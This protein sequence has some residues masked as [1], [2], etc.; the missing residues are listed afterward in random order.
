MTKLRPYQSEIVE[1]VLNAVEQC[2]DRI[3]AFSPPG[4]GKS[5]VILKVVEAFIARSTPT[6]VLCRRK[7]VIEQLA[8]RVRGLDL[9]DVRT[10]QS[11]ARR[12]KKMGH[13]GVIIIDEAHEGG[14][15]SQANAVINANPGAIVIYVT[16]TPTPDL[17]DACAVQVWGPPAQQLTDQCY[18]APLRYCGAKRPNLSSVRIRKGD[19]DPS[20]LLSV[21]DDKRIQGSILEAYNRWGRGG[22]CLGFCVSVKHAEDTADMLQKAGVPCEVLTGKDGKDETDRKLAFLEEGGLLLSISRVSAGFDLPNLKSILILRP[23]LSIQFHDQSLGRVAR[24][25]DDGGPGRV[26][27]LVGNVRRLGLFTSARDYGQRGD[28]EASGD[29]RDPSGDL[30]SI[31][32]CE[33]CRDIWEGSGTICTTCGHDNGRDRR[34]SKNEKARLDE[35][36]AAE[37]EAGLQAAKE[38]RKRQGQSIKQMAAWLR[39]KPGIPN[40]RAAW[41]QAISNMRKRLARAEREGDEVVA[42]FARSELRNAGV[43]PNQKPKPQPKFGLDGWP[44]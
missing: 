23:T 17:L 44:L 24:L 28:D 12:L 27:D 2:A 30:L 33:S 3:G 8:D 14:V 7:K 36:D 11:A 41:D 26:I 22:P 39:K 13:F 43:D 34:I 42:S 4:S 20:D 37:V 38:L 25:K 40:A 9:V 21:M 10:V 18:L 19:Y 15:S 35:I 32:E 5:I 6:L 16:A 31:R 29:K 1:G